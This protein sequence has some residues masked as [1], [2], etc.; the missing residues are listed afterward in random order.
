MKT[1]KNFL[2]TGVG[3]FIGF[4]V[5]KHYAIKNNVIGIYRKQKPK[6]TN[7]NLIK[8]DLSKQN[9]AEIIKD[10]KLKIDTIIHCSSKT[11]VSKFKSNNIYKNNILQMQNILKL[12]MPIKNFIFLSTMSV[13]GNINSKFVKETYK[14]K[15]INEY[16]RSKLVCEK[17][18]KKYTL[19]NHISCYIF[20]LPGVVGKLSHSNF[21][22]K[23][24]NKIKNNK[25]L[26]INN[27]EEKFN[28]ILHVDYL[29]Q[30]IE[31]ALRKKNTYG[32]FN[33]G[34]VRPMKIKN[35]M[36]IFSTSLGYNKNIDWNKIKTKTFCINLEKS[37]NFGFKFKSTKENIL[38]YIKSN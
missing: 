8:L 27:P 32:I 11:P 23:V 38:R 7:I 18:L 9:L 15:N 28:N 6:L 30:N 2:V 31:F 22:S 35:I 29:I 26:N 37:R 5:A 13:Y 34:S 21:I 20:R 17:L 24:F 3:G 19:K 36:K 12:N 1:K 10:R 14:G 16:G 33:L 25:E 4:N